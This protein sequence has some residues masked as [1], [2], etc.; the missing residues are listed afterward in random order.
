MAVT[1]GAMLACSEVEA[2]TAPSTHAP[3]QA[4]AS[5]KPET[6]DTHAAATHDDNAAQHASDMSSRGSVKASAPVH[7]HPAQDH[8]I[9]DDG[10]G[11]PEPA[12][13]ATEATSEPL[14]KSAA[15]PGSLGSVAQVTAGLAVV[16]A[17]FLFAAWTLKRFG[18]LRGAG[19]G[20]VR[21]VGGVSL[22]QRERAVLVQ[23]GDSL[24]LLGVAPGS[25]RTLHVFEETVSSAQVSTQQHRPAAPDVAG[26]FAEKLQAVLNER[27]KK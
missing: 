18:P 16:L 27:V 20:A 3:A 4:S 7:A 12:H 14:S 11:S 21:I 19:A 1:L 13:T 26:G 8:D 9:A 24:L 5:D 17:L 6:H 15:I 10:H 2:S 23:V 25:V 22:G